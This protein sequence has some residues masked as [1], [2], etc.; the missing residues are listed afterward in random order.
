M[1]GNV[2]GAAMCRLTERPPTDSSDPAYAAALTSFKYPA[3]RFCVKAVIHPLIRLG[4]VC[5]LSRRS[6]FVKS[7][8]DLGD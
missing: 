4:L 1:P 3:I 8:I 5:I 6:A 2:C 7:C